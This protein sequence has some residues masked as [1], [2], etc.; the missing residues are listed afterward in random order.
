MSCARAKIKLTA[1]E[2]A[3]FE[4]HF[5]WKTGDPAEAVDLT[6]YTGTCHIREKISDEEI[7]FTLANGTGV[8]IEDQAVTEGGYYLYISAEDMEGVCEKHKTRQLVY[9]LRLTSS[10]GV[11]R[12]QQ[13]GE[14]NIE[15][16]VTRPWT[17]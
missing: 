12:M 9:D 1:C 16:A 4:K 5:I 3:T 10:D 2:G 13:F 15:P 6:G 8:V 14:F 17:L 7:V 11:V